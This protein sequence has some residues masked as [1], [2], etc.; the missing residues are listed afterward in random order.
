MRSQSLYSILGESVQPGC[1]GPRPQNNHQVIG[2]NLRPQPGTWATAV[3]QTHSFIPRPW[4][5]D[6]H[7]LPTASLNTAHRMEDDVIDLGITGSQIAPVQTRLISNN[8]FKSQSPLPFDSNYSRLYCMDTS[9]A[10]PY[11][12]SFAC[13][14]FK[15]VHTRTCMYACVCVCV[16][17]YVLLQIYMCL[18]PCM[19]NKVTAAYSGK[20]YAWGGNCAVKKWPIPE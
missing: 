9:V 12:W 8:Y 11:L 19:L 5:A 18:Y 13:S 16:C 4:R 1:P 10:L 17:G 6:R 7:F 2:G 14:I 20:C 3:S 15:L